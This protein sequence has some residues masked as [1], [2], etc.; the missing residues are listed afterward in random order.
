M[1]WDYALNIVNICYCK[2]QFNKMLIGQKQDKQD[3]YMVQPE[4]ENSGNRKGRYQ[5]DAQRG[6]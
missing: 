1:L 2:Y 5:Q 6:S 3:V 4:E